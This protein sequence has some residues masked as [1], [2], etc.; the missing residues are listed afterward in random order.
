MAGEDRNIHTVFDRMLPRETRERALRQKGHVFWLY[1]L[2]GSGKSTLA[3]ALEQALFERGHFAQVL[4]G[5]NIRSGLCKDLGFSDG[6]RAENI[7]RVAEVAKLLAHAGVVTLA[8]FITPTAGLRTQ[9][10]EIVGAADFSDIYVKASYETCRNRD[11]K[12]LYAK[13]A[14]GGVSNFTGKDSAFEAP[15]APDLLIDTEA[16]ALDAAIEQAL[17]F[18][19]PRIAR[20]D[21]LV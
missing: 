20:P 5:D 10:R 3:I 12:G 15:E 17:G 8:S 9:A 6:A 2:S 18:I 19:L 11:P 1:G 16:Y 7:R 4:D 21:L 14:A 13:A